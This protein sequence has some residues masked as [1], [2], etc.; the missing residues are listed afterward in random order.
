MTIQTEIELL[1]NRHTKIVATLGPASSS[2]ESVYDLIQAGVNVFRLNMSHGDHQT[3]RALFNN[4]RN[5]SAKA[6]RTVA[7]LADLCGPKIRVGK[8]R[9]GGIKLIVGEQVWITTED[10]IGAPGLIPSQYEALAD[11]V[12]CGDRILL[13]DG[14]M[15][16]QVESVDAPR[17]QC[18][19]LQGGELKD[20]KGINLPGVE[21]SAP[22]LT[23]KDKADARFMLDLGVD[24][25]ALSFV[26][27]AND[28]LALQ[29]LIDEHLAD[30]AIIAK[31]ERPGALQNVDAILDVADG[32]MV[33][34]GDLGV[35]LPPE[36]VPIVQRDL[37]RRARLKSKPVIIATQ[38]LESMIENARPTRAE[39]SDVSHAVI[40]GADAIMLSAETAS[41]SYPVLTVEM[42]HR[43]AHQAEG[44]LWQEGAFGQL[45]SRRS[46]PPLPFGE[47]MARA[48]ATL[49]RDLLVR[50]IFVISMSGMSASSTCSARPSAPVV[51]IS[52]HP[53]ICRR[54]ALIWGAIPYLAESSELDNSIELSRRLARD[55]NLASSGE[56]VLLVQGFSAN[57][58]DSTPSVTLLSV[59]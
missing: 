28:V 25:I 34:R 10:Q 53:A 38:M 55:L 13:A 19:V 7:I 29:A 54:N 46:S 41:G 32:I 23:N 15:E 59:P 20:R 36:Q 43:I 42:M 9:D 50:A 6:D 26:L 2:R 27:H 3:H 16:L 18:T 57:P 44:F 37:V 49:S 4:I 5:A 33:A 39:V 30:A 47:A 40:S 11:D 21:L 31:I 45:G 51:A 14:M 22:C 35:E 52:S 8:F 1:Q 58:M 24:F 56:Y 48:T 17:I 12:S